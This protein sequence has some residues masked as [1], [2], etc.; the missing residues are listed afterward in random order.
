MPEHSPHPPIET[1]SGRS[2]GGGVRSRRPAG[3]GAVRGPRIRLPHR[4]AFVGGAQ[5]SPTRSAST[6]PDA[7]RGVSS[8]RS[9]RLVH[10]IRLGAEPI[11]RRPPFT[12]THPSPPTPRVHKPSSHGE[13]HRLLFSRGTV[14][15][16]RQD[17]ALLALPNAVAVL[18]GDDA[19]RPAGHETYID[20]PRSAAARGPTGAPIA[21]CLSR[22]RK[23]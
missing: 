16:S 3:S 18:G 13:G 11:A 22:P 6:N 2:L 4:P 10:T 17:P 15:S 1:R 20:V 12:D 7:S 8:N 23:K 21:T 14:W 5:T 19:P 9:P